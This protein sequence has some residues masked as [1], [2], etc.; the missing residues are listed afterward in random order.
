MITM[1]DPVSEQLVLGLI[2]S[3]MF[4]TNYWPPNIRNST[5]VIVLSDLRPV[6]HPAASVF[7]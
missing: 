2:Q 4:N 6:P 7:K 1:L 5:H 3:Y